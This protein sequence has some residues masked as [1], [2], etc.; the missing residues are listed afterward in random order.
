MENEKIITIIYCPDRKGIIANIT[1]WFFEKNINIIHSQQCTIQEEGTMFFMR[2]EA[3]AD[4]KN[5]DKKVFEK[6]LRS[7]S[8]KACFSYNLHYTSQ[9]ERIA[10][11]VSKTSHCLYEILSYYDEGTLP[12][13]DIR[14]VIGNH[15]DL[16]SVADKFDI[17][18]YYLPIAENGKKEQE[19]KVI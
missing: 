14:M 15:N 7:F 19:A 12:G 13:A 5:L 16:K 4:D 8:K 18:F 1:S 2:I 11:M 9:K 3:E 17:P 6:D 10:I